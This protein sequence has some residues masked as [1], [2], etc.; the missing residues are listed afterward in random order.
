MPGAELSSLYFYDVDF[1]DANFTDARFIGCRFEGN[2]RVGSKTVTNAEQLLRLTTKPDT[3]K[4]KP[5]SGKAKPETD[6]ESC[7]VQ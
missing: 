7:V 4:A 2:C 1:T 5:D 3:G 6:R